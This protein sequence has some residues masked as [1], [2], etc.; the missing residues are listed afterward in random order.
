MKKEETMVKDFDKK[1]IKIVNNLKIN[2]TFFSSNFEAKTTF[3]FLTCLF[4][5]KAWIIL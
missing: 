2:L 5:E 3:F 4:E 1:K